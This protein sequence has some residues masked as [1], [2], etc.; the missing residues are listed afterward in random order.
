M[1]PDEI[2]ETL[3]N[4]YEPT[5]KWNGLIKNLCMWNIFWFW[6]LD[7]NSIKNS[8]MLDWGTKDVR[9]NA[10]QSG[11]GANMIIINLRDAWIHLDATIE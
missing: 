3:P 10:K 2:L 11:D 8:T 5:W 4:I 1:S 6:V 7:L 9:R